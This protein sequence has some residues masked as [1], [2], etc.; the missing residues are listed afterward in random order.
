MQ[1]QL[2]A[3]APWDHVEPPTTNTGGLPQRG[4]SENDRH[5]QTQE[6]TVESNP[7]TSAETPGQPLPNLYMGVGPDV[8]IPESFTPSLS[9]SGA[10]FGSGYFSRFSAQEAAPLT[11]LNDPQLSLLDHFPGLSLPRSDPKTV[12]TGNGIGSD[13]PQLPSQQ[14]NPSPGPTSHREISPQTQFLQQFMEDLL[15]L[16][17]DLIR[18]TLEDPILYDPAPM[19]PGTSGANS[20]PPQSEC[21]IDTTFLLTQRLIRLLRRGA[22]CSPQ[23]TVAQNA[24]WQSPLSASSPFSSRFQQLLTRATPQNTP[25]H[26]DTDSPQ[27][28]TKLDQA[29]VLHALS[30]Y[31]RLIEAYHNTFSQTAEKFGSALADGSPIPLP[32]LQIGAFAVDDPASHIALVIQ[33]ALR[34]LDRLGDLVNKLTTPFGSGEKGDLGMGGPSSPSNG[35]NVIKTVMATVRNH[36]S[37]LMQAA[38]RL[39]SFCHKAQQLRD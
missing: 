30:T 18:H 13:V 1:N 3:P 39:Q 28:E 8:T 36:E 14:L 10:P 6:I 37:Q 27:P 16:D 23:S 9:L 25:G 35:H 17:I 26:S 31:L 32:S 22:H 21:A 24:H 38:A 12:P 11:P 34:L 15:E 20:S 19:T 5:L 29:S 33:S 4:Y 2:S 7:A